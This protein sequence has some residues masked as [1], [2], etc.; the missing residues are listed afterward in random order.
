MNGCR[1]RNGIDCA[2]P[3]RHSP[4]Q[5][6][7]VAGGSA[8][9]KQSDVDGMTSREFT[10]E[11]GELWRVWDVHPDSLERR[12]ANDHHLRPAHERR[13]TPQ[14]RVRVS[15]PVMSHGWLAFENR[16]ERRRLAPIPEGWQE[17][18]A[19]QLRHLLADARP[20]GRARR[21]IE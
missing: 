17:M 3:A 15:D 18:D 21:L 19:T 14:V 5:V 6:G 20:T 10:D 8:A 2:S 16:Y 7:L 12:M 9:L 1:S 11:R 4:C 13:R